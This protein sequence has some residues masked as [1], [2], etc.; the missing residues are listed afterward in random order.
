MTCTES[1]STG[2]S[3]YYEESVKKP[4]RLKTHLSRSLNK[5]NHDVGED[6]QKYRNHQLPY[7]IQRPRTEGKKKS[8][9]LETYNSLGSCQN[10]FGDEP[11]EHGRTRH[12]I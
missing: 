4:K 9:L 7:E 3:A 12:P 6:D 1:F 10:T 8:A 11:P 5:R 2:R